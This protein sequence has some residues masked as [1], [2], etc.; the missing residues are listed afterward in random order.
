MGMGLSGLPLALMLNS[1]IKYILIMLVTIGVSFI[2]TN[3]LGFD[4]DVIPD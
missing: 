4:D 2:L 1:P 3:V